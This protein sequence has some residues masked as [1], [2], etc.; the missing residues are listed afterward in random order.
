MLQIMKLIKGESAYWIN[1]EKLKKEFFEW[2]DEYFVTAVSESII[3]RN[4]IYIKNQETHH[5]KKTF[6]HELNSFLNKCGF[7]LH[8]E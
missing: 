3:K 7:A 8:K 4:Q 6:H 1:K 5:K 2:Q